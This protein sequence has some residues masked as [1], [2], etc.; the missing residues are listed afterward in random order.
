MREFTLTIG[1]SAAILRVTAAKS[2][3]E[4]TKGFMFVKSS[5]KALLLFSCNFIHTFFMRFPIDAVY[6]DKGN[7]I[8]RVQR[9]IKP[10][11][12]PSPVIQASKVLEIPCGLYDTSNLMP[13]DLVSFTEL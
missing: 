11:R 13:G 3:L 2:I 8:I 4:K 10:Y 7:R 5:K 1:N 12:I 6:M 9:D